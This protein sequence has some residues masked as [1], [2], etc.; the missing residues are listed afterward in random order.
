MLKYEKYCGEKAHVLAMAWNGN[1]L[2]LSDLFVCI[3][4]TP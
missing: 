4:G 3:G 1:S 2:K